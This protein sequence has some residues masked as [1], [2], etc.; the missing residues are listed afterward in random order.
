MHTYFSPW[1]WITLKDGEFLFEDGY[2]VDPDLF[3]KDRQNKEWET[4]WN[5]F[6]E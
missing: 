2:T 3:W 6:P 1:E 4:G 5:Y